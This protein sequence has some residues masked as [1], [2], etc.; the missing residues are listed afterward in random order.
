MSFTDILDR[1]N[2]SEWIGSISEVGMGVPFQYLYLNHPGASKTIVRTI[3]PYHKGE[4]PKISGK[5]LISEEMAQSMC[6]VELCNILNKNTFDVLSIN[7]K[8]FSVAVTASHAAENDPG[9]SHGWISFIYTDHKN[10]VGDTINIH[11]NIKS[12][13]SRQDAGLLYTKIIFWILNF[14]LLNAFENWN[15]AII[16]LNKAIDQY[17]IGVD[18]INSKTDPVPM[19]D[20]LML[21]AANNFL[22]YFNGKFERAV[23]FLRKNNQIYRGSFNPPTL[24]HE[25]NGRDSIFSID[26]HNIRK[27]DCSFADVEH[28]VN[29]LN[30]LNKAVIISNGYPIFA[31]FHKALMQNFKLKSIVYIVGCDTFNAI[32]NKKYTP[33]INILSDFLRNTGA[34]SFI[35]N[36]RN[37]FSL[38]FKDSEYEPLIN[39][40]L[41]TEDP[42]FVDISSTS[43]RKG[44]FAT[45]SGSIKKYICDNK[46]YE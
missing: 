40:T 45:I 11:F 6:S 2:D 18:I 36:E 27:A 16:N 42:H 10:N 26:M 9:M 39:Y 22:L 5:K 43:V 15:D 20:H 17:H 31:D 8:V 37:G 32:L 30:I 13:V 24:A 46:L 25:D 41:R 23:D 44:N 29:M 7:K 34:G 3:S 28:R 21:A 33:N 4:Q 12:G 19:R 1:L 14:K 38:E 35:V